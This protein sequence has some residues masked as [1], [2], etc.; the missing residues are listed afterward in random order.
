MLVRLFVEMGT[1]DEAHGAAAALVLIGKADADGARALPAVPA[2]RRGPGPGASDRGGLAEADL[3]PRGGLGAVA[4]PGDARRRRWPRARA[5]L[6][7]ET[8]LK[9][10]QRRDVASDPS[11]PCKVFAYG[12]AVLGV[13]TPEVYL[14]PGAP[15]R[16]R[17][18]QRA[19]RHRRRARPRWSSA[20]GWPRCA[21][22]S[23]WPSSPG[24]RWRRCA[25]IT[26]CAGRS[27]VPTLAELEIVVRAAI[28]LVN[29]DDRGSRR[30]GRVRRPVHD[31]PRTDVDAPAR[32]ATDR[33]GAALSGDCPEPPEPDMGRW[34]RGGLLLDHPRRVSC[35]P[36]ISTWRRGS[37]RPL[38]RRST[39]RRSSAISVPGA[40]RTAISSCARSSACAP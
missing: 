33:A 14:A 30:R 16:R 37:A 34:S 25:R 35:W 12:G 15:R 3:S 1:L 24:G 10:K 8:G 23:S 29:P 39:R 27:F 20:R 11:L 19:G 6:F 5:R 7:K 2:E 21:R 36:A 32:R 38:T 13:Q 4:D 26:C 18:R 17:R 40:C 9:K 22:T 31:V 28:R